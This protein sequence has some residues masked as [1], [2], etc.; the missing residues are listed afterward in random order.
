MAFGWLAGQDLMALRLYCACKVII[1]YTYFLLLMKSVIFLQA[2]YLKF[3]DVSVR[4]ESMPINGILDQLNC[5]AS[6]LSI[7][8]NVGQCPT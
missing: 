2:E 6:L 8:R 5:Y 7:T 4:T 3:I 1:F